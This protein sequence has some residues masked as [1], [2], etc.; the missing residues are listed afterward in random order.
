MSGA[1][2]PAIPA[3]S[4]GARSLA[5]R[6]FPVALVILMIGIVL[7]GFW[8]YYAGLL[9]GGEAAHWLIHLHA[10]IFS[11][12]MVLLLAQVVLV[13]RRRVATHRRL[14]RFGIAWGVLVLLLGAVISIVA[15]AMNVLAG[16]STLDEAASFLLLP[17]V[18]MLLFAGFFAAAVVYRGRRDLHKRLMLLATIALLFAPAARFA[19]E[20][21]PPAIL[22]V[23]LLPLFLAMGHDL[24]TRGRVE[25]VY[26]IGLAVLLVAFARVGLMETEAWREVGRAMLQLALPQGSY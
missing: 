24:A 17:T 8:P 3:G 19:F 13:F 18:D 11:G 5:V 16:R 2:N 1:A 9:R 22:L 6:A 14:G 26:V 21:G 20:A 7:A 23:W 25:R 10:A 4:G 15:P 12:W